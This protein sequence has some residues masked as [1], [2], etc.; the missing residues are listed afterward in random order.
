MLW[1]EH[2]PATLLWDSSTKRLVG[3]R[4]L[5]FFFSSKTFPFTA[6]LGWCLPCSRCA[7]SCEEPDGQTWRNIWGQRG[8]GTEVNN[9]AQIAYWRVELVLGRKLN[10]F[11]REL[12]CYSDVN[13]NASKHKKHMRVIWPTDHILCYSMCINN[14][15]NKFLQ[16]LNINSKWPPDSFL[17]L[18]TNT[19]IHIWELLNCKCKCF[20]V[21]TLCNGHTF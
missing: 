13:F 9:D 11:C 1:L 19:E 15:T 20:L 8:G 3:R 12:L 14:R 10:R 4:H 16:R 7:S 17:A 6:L 18:P 2:T 21:D 5:Y